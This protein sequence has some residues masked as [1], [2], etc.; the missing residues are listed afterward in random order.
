MLSCRIRLLLKNI[1]YT[2]HHICGINHLDVSWTCHQRC[3]SCGVSGLS[4]S[5]A[6]AQETQLCGWSIPYSS[7][8]STTLPTAVLASSTATSTQPLLPRW[9]AWC[10]SACL[11]LWWPCRGAGRWILWISPQWIHNLLTT[12]C[13]STLPLAHHISF[14]FSDGLPLCSLS[15][16][17]W[18]LRWGCIGDFWDQQHVWPWCNVS[19]SSELQ[20]IP[21]VN[22]QAQSLVSLPVVQ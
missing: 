14:S 12:H 18:V 9:P 8:D 4:T 16:E 22:F 11:S 6:L 7:P 5:D 21:Q 3:W 17:R 19:G 2:N 13:S 1:I 15:R 10:P 20:L